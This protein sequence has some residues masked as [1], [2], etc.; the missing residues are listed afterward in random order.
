[1]KRTMDIVNLPS[2]CLLTVINVSVSI[3][4]IEATYYGALTQYDLSYTFVHFGVSD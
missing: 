3:L 2:K 4:N 1:M